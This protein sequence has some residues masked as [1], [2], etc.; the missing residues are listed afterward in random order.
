MIRPLKN[1]TY[2][3]QDKYDNASLVIFKDTDIVINATVIHPYVLAHLNMRT[4]DTSCSID[5]STDDIDY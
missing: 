4:T 1:Q 3:I 2:D 5:L